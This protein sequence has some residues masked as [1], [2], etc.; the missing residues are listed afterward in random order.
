MVKTKGLRRTAQLCVMCEEDSVHY[1]RD[2]CREK[3]ALDKSNNEDS[4]ITLKLLVQEISR[5]QNGGRP[6]GREN[7]LLDVY[8]EKPVRVS[9]RILVPVKEHPRF[10][11]VGK[12][13]GPRGNSLKK[14]Q[15]E[16]MTKM[17]VLG[18][19]SM[20]NKQHEEELRN[21][22]DPKHNHLQEDLHVEVTAFASP[23]EAYA[24][25]AMALTEVRKYL[26]PDGN[27]AI[28]QRQMAEIQIL[29]KMQD[30]QDDK[31][32]QD[33]RSPTTA[34]ADDHVHITT[35]DSGQESDMSASPTS[36]P[37]PLYSNNNH[38]T[39]S[40]PS[41][42]GPG[43]ASK[44]SLAAST[45]STGGTASPTTMVLCSD[46][47]GA[48]KLYDPRSKS[49][50]ERI[51]QNR[52]HHPDADRLVLC[53]ADI[54]ECFSTKSILDKIIPLHLK[55]KYKRDIDSV[56]PSIGEEPLWKKMK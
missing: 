19:G 20:R 21:S 6:P 56:V 38:A 53:P 30:K 23:A 10:N 27:D 5:V 42:T 35:D 43:T 46:K 44:P 34:V 17:A 8:N 9:A 37:S 22:S 26:I 54:Q 41:P 47:S 36:E 25:L 48:S 14:L 32:Q 2:L 24:R 31:P 39:P 33:D 29:K 11:F 40:H 15:D 7:R 49:I 1:L 52:D 16:T 55:D 4:Q 45:K 51:R 50:L 3:E 12:L 28:R 13:L 18:R